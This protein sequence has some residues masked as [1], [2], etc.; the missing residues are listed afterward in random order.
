MKP[1]KT[2]ALG[3]ALAALCACSTTS[4]TDMVTRN[5]PLEV[6]RMDAQQ[7]TQQ[8]R[9]YSLQSVRFT[10][11]EQLSVSEAN[12]YYPIADIV[13][14]GDAPG[15][16]RAQIGE[17]FE[18]AI[19]RAGSGL[20]GSV[21]VTVDVT[22]ERFHSLTERTR[23]SVGGVH[24]IRFVMTV[25]DVRTGEVLDGPR[26]VRA[27]LAAFGGAAAIAA[28]HAGQGQKVRV[29]DHLASVF[30]AELTGPATPV[31]AVRSAAGS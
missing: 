11:P 22:L 2:F 9:N 13:W 19:N 27:D 24:S 26:R 8:M 18:T 5:A 12:S 1:I 28:D 10:A 17:I 23:Y 25:L 21:P 15:D 31:G 14:R 4:S 16:R 7:T 6:P 30:A 29:T 3:A 20:S